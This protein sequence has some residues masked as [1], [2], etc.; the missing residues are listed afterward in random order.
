MVFNF[1]T[2]DVL[3]DAI[4]AKNK[5]KNDRWDEY[6]RVVETS[7]DFEYPS[8]LRIILDKAENNEPH[9]RERENI[10][11]IDAEDNCSSEDDPQCALFLGSFKPHGKSYVLEDN[12]NSKPLFIEYEV[13]SGLEDER[14]TERRRKMGSGANP[15]HCPVTNDLV[16]NQCG[17]DV[18][19]LSSRKSNV[20]TV[21][22]LDN[23]LVSQNFG[24]RITLGTGNRYEGDDEPSKKNKVDKVLKGNNVVKG[25]HGPEIQA[26]VQIDNGQC[27][28]KPGPR[29]DQATENQCELVDQAQTRDKDKVVY[30]RKS[31]KVV[32]RVNVVKDDHEANKKAVVQVDYRDP[33]Q[34]HG[35]SN[36][37]M[38]KNQHEDV[39]QPGLG[40]KS[41]VQSQINLQ[42]KMVTGK[43]IVRGD[44][45]ANKRAVVQKSGPR[46][47]AR[48]DKN[49]GC[50][51]TKLRKVVVKEKNMVRGDVGASKRVV[52]KTE[53]DGQHQK[54]VSR[55][56]G[57]TRNQERVDRGK[58]VV[59]RKNVVKEEVEAS[60][61]VVVQ[62]GNERLS[63]KPGSRNDWLK[64]NH[65]ARVD[66]SRQ[67]KKDEVQK[68]VKEENVVQGDN[69]LSNQNNPFGTSKN[70]FHCNAQARFRN[71]K[72]ADVN[73]EKEGDDES[74]SEVQILDSAAF[75]TRGVLSSVVPSKGFHKSMKDDD[76]QD[77]GGPSATDEFRKRVLEVLKKPYD[78]EEHNRHREV[79][80]VGNYLNHHYPDLGKKLKKHR[81]NRRK[82]LAI[83]RGFFFWLQ[84]MFL[85]ANAQKA[86]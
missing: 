75:Q 26:A 41:R 7:P 38:M 20:R 56:V 81:Y 73:Q 49:D 28:E 48:P 53:N 84:G 17:Y 70:Q 64:R 18:K 27:Y 47:Q 24:K 46:K 51:P 69:G 10:M 32:K 2:C 86:D 12:K 67:G 54:P 4:L 52:V 5:C 25:D 13:E 72:A 22:Q 79:A 16:Q 74:A 61:R 15:E 68:M 21:V 82:C 1:G 71:A 57:V 63:L 62:M 78:K 50:I 44:L 42:K 3:H 23:R 37:R 66:Q 80:R 76:S 36:R 30:Q 6:K 55:N 83:L 19:A 33:Y 39:D 11:D 9:R 65:S 8:I 59:K 45:E 34:K 29:N 14:E 31:S 58:V 60:K 40:E 43:N 35:P 77:L 85:S